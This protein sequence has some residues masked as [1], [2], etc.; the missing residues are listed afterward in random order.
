MVAP[1]LPIALL[2]L[3]GPWKTATIQGFQKVP[4]PAE[5]V[6]VSLRM[7]PVASKFNLLTEAVT[8]STYH[9]SSSV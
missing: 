9:L 2:P 7:T 8:T 1:W 4:S 6:T 3:M 5:V